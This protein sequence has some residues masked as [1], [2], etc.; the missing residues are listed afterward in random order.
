MSVKGSESV[1]DGDNLSLG[2]YGNEI[3][4][5]RKRSSR[6]E[7][8]LHRFLCTFSS[9]L[10]PIFRISRL[11]L[12]SCFMQM[13]GPDQLGASLKDKRPLWDVLTNSLHPTGKYDCFALTSCEAL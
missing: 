4:C 3:S 8:L 10:P 2:R 12:S 1:R 6:N 13:N 11:L 9:F 5:R 7:T